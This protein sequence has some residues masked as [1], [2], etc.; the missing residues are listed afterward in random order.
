VTSGRRFVGVEI[1]EHY[2]GVAC[3]RMENAQRQAQL[4]A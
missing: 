2:F 4:F 3:E 1:D